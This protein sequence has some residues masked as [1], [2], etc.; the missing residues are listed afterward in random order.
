MLTDCRFINPDLG[1]R[2][3]FSPT[4]GRHPSF[5]LP[6]VI[7]IALPLPATLGDGCLGGEEA[8][9]R[10]EDRTASPHLE[11]GEHSSSVSVPP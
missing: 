6:S 5:P 2:T 1:G 7:S 9:A 10:R 11:E 4:L 8:V 3:I